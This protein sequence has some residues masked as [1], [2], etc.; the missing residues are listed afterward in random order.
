M[1][2]G[3]PATPAGRTRA[4]GFGRTAPAA[5]GS[6]AGGLGSAPAAGRTAPA[7]PGPSAESRASILLACP[8]E[9]GAVPGASSSSRAA[10]VMFGVMTSAWAVSSRMPCTSSGVK[11]WYSLPW[12][13]ITGSTKR[14]APGA[15]KS[16]KHWDTSSI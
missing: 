12:S 15:E 13:P 7:T 6:R 5:G 1:G 11:P 9:R 2:M 8:S 3:R 14:T 16:E 10:S 4:V